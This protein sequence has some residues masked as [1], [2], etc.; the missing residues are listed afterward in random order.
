MNIDTYGSVWCIDPCVPIASFSVLNDN[1]LKKCFIWINLRP[2][3]SIENNSKKLK[4]DHYPY[5]LQE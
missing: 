1:E 4:N 3:Y 5:L 2:M